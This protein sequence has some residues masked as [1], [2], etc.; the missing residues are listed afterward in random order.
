[1]DLDGSLNVFTDIGNK[2]I[3][4]KQINVDGTASLNTYC[5]TQDKEEPK[6]EFITRQEFDAVI[7]EF[8][9]LIL[10]MQG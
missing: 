1:M 2:K 7:K 10:N 8:Q 3:Y 5:L 6:V 4:T 9:N